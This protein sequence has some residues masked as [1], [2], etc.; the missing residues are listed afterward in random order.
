MLKQ[1]LW[2][3]TARSGPV[4]PDLD[5]PHRLWKFRGRKPQWPHSILVW[6]SGLVEQ[7]EAPSIETLNRPEL[8][9]WIK[10]GSNFWIDT[11]EQVY[12]WLVDVGYEFYPDD[13][14]G[15]V[16][17]PSGANV[18]TNGYLSTY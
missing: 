17:P 6:S 10:G 5:G 11:D 7:I 3:E 4:V 18:Y 15:G 13:D 12:E 9:L 16:T 14:G 2:P 8:L 1:L